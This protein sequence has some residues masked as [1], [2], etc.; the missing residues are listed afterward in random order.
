MSNVDPFTNDAVCD[1]L[2]CSTSASATHRL[3]AGRCGRQLAGI[4]PAR[5]RMPSPMTRS[6]ALELLVSVRPRTPGRV[7]RM[8]PVV[9][10]G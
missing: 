5:L 3:Q 9:P 4:V 6:R 2:V 1:D 10:R 8:D 7:G